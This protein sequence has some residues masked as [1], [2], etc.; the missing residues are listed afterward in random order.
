M[1]FLPIA[2]ELARKGHDVTMV[3]SGVETSHRNLKI[4]DI[5]SLKA[6]LKRLEDELSDAIL[7]GKLN[8]LQIMTQTRESLSKFVSFNTHDLIRE[9][10]NDYNFFAENTKY[11]AV[12]AYGFIP[13][14]QIG[15]YLSR[16]FNASL[17]LYSPIQI[18]P[19]DMNW[20][21]GQ[22]HNPSI[23]PF[24]MSNFRYATVGSA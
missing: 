8:Q 12:A 17:I 18:S 23:M 4:V 10:S 9:L 7:G 2:Q 3:S 14:N 19:Q 11:D 22:P 1:T 15:Y 5:K 6:P 13:T 20:A 21:L 24:F 16:R